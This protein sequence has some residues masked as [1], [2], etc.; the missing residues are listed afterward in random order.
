[1]KSTEEV[2][3]QPREVLGVLGGLGPLASAEF[4]RTIYECSLGEYEQNSPNVVLLSDPAFPD[5]TTAILN[6][7]E[8]V[9]IAPLTDSLQKLVD[10]GAGKIVICC[11]T[12]H[13]V[14]H[15]APAP[16]RNRVVSLLD[17]I[18]DHVAANG[19]RHLIACTK[20]TRQ[21][22]LFENHTRWDATKDHFILP[23]DHDLDTIHRMIYRLKSNSPPAT[24]APVL[25]EI[26]EKYSTKSFVSGCTEIHLLVK[27]Y[28]SPAAASAGY[29]FVDPLV[30][31]A[32]QVAEGRL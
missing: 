5:R 13:A 31:I 19:G 8:H 30:I 18:F 29:G 10:L 28:M 14:L 4:M 21:M 7:E 27:H 22:G 17:V 2:S 24:E 1:M 23:D 11:M 16:L 9:L 25:E 20:G 15:W 3:A 32:R 6:G 26:L 12:I